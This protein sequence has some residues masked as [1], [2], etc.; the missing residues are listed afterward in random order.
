[1][2]RLIVGG[3]MKFGFVVSGSVF[4]VTLCDENETKGNEIM[5]GR[6]EATV[7]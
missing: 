7:K 2:C 4:C 6:P 1:M 5:I 3:E